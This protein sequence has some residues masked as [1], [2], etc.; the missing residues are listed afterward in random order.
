MDDLFQQLFELADRTEIPPEETNMPNTPEN[1]LHIAATKT[2]VGKS[3]LTDLIPILEQ[4]YKDN[5]S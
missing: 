2:I 1:R 4:I 3:I 5:R